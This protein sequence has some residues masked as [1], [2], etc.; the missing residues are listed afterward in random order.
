LARGEWSSE[1][2]IRFGDGFEFDRGTLELRQRETP[3]KLERIPCA[4]LLLLLERNG[5]LVTRA[6]IIER[7]WGKDVFVDADN[8]I[9]V[10][11]RKI[12]LAI[13]DNPEQPQYLQ[14]LTGRG[15]RFIAPVEPPAAV[16]DKPPPEPSHPDLLPP[17]P[18]AEP[19][20]SRFFPRRSIAGIVVLA[21][22]AFGVYFAWSRVHVRE[23]D[24]QGRVMLAVLPFENLTGDPAQ[25]YFSDG[26]TEEMITQLGKL[27]PQR[28]GVIARTSVMH[29]KHTTQGFSQIAGELGV[30]YI[31]EGSVRR[32]AEKVRITA[33]LIQVKDQTHL[34]AHEYDREMKDLLAL[35]EDIARQVAE[36]TRL[37]L[38]RNAPAVRGAAGARSP[39][40]VAAHDLYLKG[41]YCWNKR[42]TE[43]LQQAGDY[44]AQA[45]AVDPAYAEAYAGLASSYALLG[46][47]LAAPA[48]YMPKAR[49][50]AQRA[51][52]L[53]PGLPEAHAALGWIEENYEWNW[54]GAER[55]FQRAIELDPN[56]ATGHHWYAEY[57]A[58]RGRFDEALRESDI[59]RQLDPLSLIIA[60]DH[61]AILYYSR[62]YQQAIDQCRKVL[63]VEPSFPRAHIIVFAYAQMAKFPEALADIAQLQQSD[64]AARLWVMQAYVYGKMGETAEAEKA[65]EHLER[66]SRNGSLDPAILAVAYLGV[67][68]NEKALNSLEEAYLRHSNVLTT[69]RVD[70]VFDPVRSN[71][72]FI[73][74]LR[75][76]GLDESK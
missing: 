19:T 29:Y 17:E 72:R 74:L 56:Y 50:A 66:A 23:S 33:Q 21:C 26:L 3:I 49:A 41:K 68:A 2:V 38:D 44:F 75:K 70:P 13:G 34:W 71:P 62:R 73:E 52:E 39:E 57:L 12:R 53:D 20:T 32:D 7:V 64:D 11:I 67:G 46:A 24:A 43:G 42:T 37:V 61:G 76:V 31:L 5:E 47:Y 6:E 54:A 14:T 63:D 60:S 22:I 51:I 8:G 59:A 18:S 36:Q 15:Y 9:N 25:E 65:I 35:Q 10:A 4:V 55:E 1:A 28:L 16:V 45:V 30:H 40:A 48:Q 27:D 58:W 69:L